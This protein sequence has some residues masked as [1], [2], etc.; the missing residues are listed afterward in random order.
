MG[1]G[2]EVIPISSKMSSDIDGK[3]FLAK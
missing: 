3:V 2:A 1:V